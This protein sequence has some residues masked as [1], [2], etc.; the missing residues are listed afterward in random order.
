MG[1]STKFQPPPAAMQAPPQPTRFQFVLR[2]FDASQEDP[3][4]LGRR[5]FADPSALSR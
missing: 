4:A 1:V 3:A 2:P 5:S